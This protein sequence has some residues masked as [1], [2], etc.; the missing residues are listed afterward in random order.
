M[1]FTGQTTAHRDLP[2][3]QWVHSR[4]DG[5]EC[6]RQQTVLEVNLSNC[7]V[8]ILTDLTYLWG[9]N[10]FDRATHHFAEYRVVDRT[11][12]QPYPMLNRFLRENK[13]LEPGMLI[14]IHWW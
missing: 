2:D 8:E 11:V 9:D 6:V 3:G 5:K 14:W 12:A 10:N 13:G 4:G 1:E 7:P